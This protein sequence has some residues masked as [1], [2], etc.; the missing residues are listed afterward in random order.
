MMRGSRRTYRAG[1]PTRHPLPVVD[2]V[3]R[4][5]PVGTRPTHPGRE[6]RDAPATPRRAPDSRCPRRPKPPLMR[7][8]EVSE[9]AVWCRVRGGAHGRPEHGGF[10]GFSD[11]ESG[12]DPN[13]PSSEHRLAR[14][15][16]AVEKEMMTT[17][18]RHLESPSCH[19]LA[20][21]VG[22]VR[23]RFPR[24]CLSGGGWRPAVEAV[25]K[26]IH[27]LG[28][29]AHPVGRGTGYGGRLGCRRR[30]HETG[31]LLAGA[32]HRG[33]ESIGAGTHRA[34]ESQLPHH[35]GTSQT[36][37]LP[38]GWRGCRGRWGGRSRCHPWVGQPA[39]D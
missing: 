4:D 6:H 5:D 29:A 32:E 35:H 27:R 18:R 36:R 20:L 14:S 11:L 28:Q 30:S 37:D 39:P 34:V 12:K 22:H 25:P 33:A 13:H 21:D 38:A 10:D 3:C 17:C 19:D 2:G 23:C 31:D 26:E 24:Q 1:R 15:G 16:R 8:D 7:C 9:T